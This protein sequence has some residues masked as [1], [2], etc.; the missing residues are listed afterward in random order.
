MGLCDTFTGNETPLIGTDVL[1]QVSTNAGV[2]Y[3]TICGQRGCTLNMKL[4][5]IALKWKCSNR[6]T[7][8]IPGDRDWSADFDGLYMLADGTA[9]SDT[10]ASIKLLEGVVGANAVADAECKLRFVFPGSRYAEGYGYFE[11]LAFDFPVGA[12]ATAK[13]T[14]VANGALT[15]V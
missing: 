5:T 12:E 4:A 7:N 2:S 1:V 14:F 13:G 9:T 6:W 11:T 10:E 8:R 15:F 3:S